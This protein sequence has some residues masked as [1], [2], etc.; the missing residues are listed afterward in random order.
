VHFKI[1][2]LLQVDHFE[3]GQFGSLY[4]HAGGG[5][6]D[7]SPAWPQYDAR[8]TEHDHSDGSRGRRKTVGTPQKPPFSS[9]RRKGGSSTKRAGR[10]RHT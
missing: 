1:R 3:P 7:G 5:L 6:K 8:A 2:A 4:V 9:S 10:E